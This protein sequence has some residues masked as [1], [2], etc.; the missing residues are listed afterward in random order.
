M[1]VSLRSDNK[2]G[3][4]ADAF[5]MEPKRAVATILSDAEWRDLDARVKRVDEDRWLSSRYA[6]LVHRRALISLYAFNYELARV[7]TAVSEP[8]LGAIRFQWWRDALEE[9]AAGAPPRDHDVVHAIV[10]AG[11]PLRRLQALVDAHEIA[12]ETKDR[13]KEPEDA[14]AA[15]AVELIDPSSA[16][17]FVKTAAALGAAFAG[18]RR[19][20]AEPHKCALVS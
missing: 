13:G 14:L 8:M 19:G 9:L 17:A 11:L 6:S 7:R 2:S 10:D 15:L 20:D 4:P 12:F 3:A 18:A 5:H 1:V 16:Q